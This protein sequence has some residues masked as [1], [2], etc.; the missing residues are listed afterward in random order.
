MLR[1]P[2][3][4]LALPTCALARSP[5]SGHVPMSTAAWRL[6]LSIPTA[7]RSASPPEPCA[8]PHLRH[9]LLLAAPAP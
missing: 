8:L 5:Q 3:R 6:V 4:P 2:P 1:S 9:A 7:R